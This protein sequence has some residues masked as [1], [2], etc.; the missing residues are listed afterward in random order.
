MSSQMPQIL[1]INATFIAHDENHG[2]FV[3]QTSLLVL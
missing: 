3:G 1:S 2:L